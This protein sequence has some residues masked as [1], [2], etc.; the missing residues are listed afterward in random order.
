MRYWDTSAIV[1]LV[2]EE[3]GSELVR[4]WLE[5]DPTMVTWALSRLELVGAVERRARQHLI[6][7]ADRRLLLARFESLASIWDEVRDLLPVR[8]RAVSLLARHALRAA[9]AL[10]LAAADLVADGDPAS[11]QFVCLDRTL[12]AAAEREGFVVMTWPDE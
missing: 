5:Q 9:D 11:L 6:S 3:P 10:Q 1:P 12:G 8:E 4:R 7:P 2:V